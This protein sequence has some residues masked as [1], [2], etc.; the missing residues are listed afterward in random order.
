[1]ACGFDELLLLFADELRQPG[2]L[3]AL[4]TRSALPLVLLRKG[5]SLDRYF[6]EQYFFT[7]PAE[8]DGEMA[9]LGVR[10]SGEL[11]YAGRI[12]VSAQAFRFTVRSVDSRYVPAIDVEGR[13][14][15]A[16]QTL[17]LT[18]TIAS[19][20]VAARERLSR[21]PLKVSPPHG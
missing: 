1:L 11:T 21:A 9:L 16:N 19:S 8:G 15:L 4:R 17:E 18:K 12:Q 6:L 10:P 20:R 2:S 14:D 5:L 7:Q 3:E 13:Y